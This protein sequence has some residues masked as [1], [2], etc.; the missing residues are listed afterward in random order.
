MAQYIRELDPYDH[1][2]VVHTYPDQ[3]D[4]VY[5]P[6]LGQPGVIAGASLQNAYDA[7]HERT[8]RWV[9][10]SAAAGMPWVVANDE[11]GSANLG[12]PPDVGYPGFTG[13]DAQGNDIQSMHDIRKYTLWGNLM[14]GGAGVEYYAGYQLPDN[15]LVLENFRSRDQ[16]WAYAGIALDFF[17]RER[18]PF[19]Q[20][21]NADV[22]VGNYVHDNRVYCLAKPGELYLVYLPHG[23]SADLDLGGATGTFAVSWFDPRAGGALRRGSVASVAAGRRVSLGTA[24]AEPGEDWLV[25]VRKAG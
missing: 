4:T 5:S 25:V 9:R 24:P 21:V 11:Q 18:I 23:G 1:L 14:A 2:V 8:V 22:L 3:Q 7:T 15:D 20:M 6:L 12:V 13:R 17:R 10:A 16:S 19:W